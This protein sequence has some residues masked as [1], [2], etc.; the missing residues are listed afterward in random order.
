MWL[1]HEIIMVYS[2]V[3]KR[4]DIETLAFLS[5]S[6]DL[7]GLYELI[8]HLASQLMGVCA[9]DA[10]LRRKGGMETFFVFFNT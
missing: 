10:Q 9:L 1:L 8:S 4:T 5:L 6:F 2:S 7:C 3:Y